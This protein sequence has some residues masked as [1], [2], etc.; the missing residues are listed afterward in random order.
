VRQLTGL[1]V[2]PSRT[3]VWGHSQG[4]HAALWTGGVA[5][6]YAADV[7]IS[8]VAA[9]APATALGPLIEQAKDTIV[10]RVLSA[11]IIN[12]YSE[13][14]SDVRVS[15]YV[16]WRYRFL[17]HDMGRRCLV[18][19]TA[20]VSIV[21]STRVEGSIFSQSPSAG[22]LGTRVEQNVPRLPIAAPVMIAQ[23]AGDILVL[24]ALQSQ[25]VADRC[26]AG[27]VIEYRT[28]AGRDHIGLI[29]R[30]SALP[31]DLIQW[32]Q[33]IL[34]GAAPPAACQTIAR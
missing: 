24:P 15:D 30:Q 8:G 11:Y 1:T 32:T 19:P 21:E 25:Y 33:N 23:G 14:Y 26:A 2:D 13:T 18:P 22:P 10:G 7:P 31:A 4:G 17:A 16:P 20:I 34:A 12:Q 29:D 3:F 9:L 28:Y 6:S 27:Q 5:P